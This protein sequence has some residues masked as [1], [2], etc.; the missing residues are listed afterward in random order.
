M[1]RPGGKIDNYD[2]LNGLTKSAIL[3][4]ALD[5]EAASI[6]LKQ[7]EQKAVEELTREIASL[8]EIP[9]KIRDRV[10][11]EFYDIALAQRWANE[12][13]LEYAK[14]LLGKSLPAGDADRILQQ[15]SQQVRKT[16]F[17]F[18]Q[19][20]ESQNLLT[21]IQDEHPQPSR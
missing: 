10:V 5:E 21:F 9:D 17:A 6:I 4:L 2:E 3:L 11:N 13:G 8:R 16:P 19:K 20:A 18:L 15:I 1:A 7:M 12:G 14:Q